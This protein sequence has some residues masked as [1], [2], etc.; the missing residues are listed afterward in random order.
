MKQRD[1]DLTHLKDAFPPMPENCRDALLTAA[2]SV[3]EEQPMKRTSFRA[4]LIVAAILIVTM[5]AAIAATQMGWVDFFGHYDNIRVPKAAQETLNATETSTYTVGPLTF[6]VKQLLADGHIAMSAVQARA[7]DGSEALYSTDEIFDPIGAFGDTALLKHFN[8]TAE[9]PWVDAAK[10]LNIPLY[11]VRA[12]LEINEEYIGGEAMEDPLWNEDGSIVYFN[13]PATNPETVKDSLPATLYLAVR[14][15]D[16]ATGEEV[17]KWTDRKDITIPVNGV[18]ES[19]NYLP[20]DGKTLLGFTVESVTAERTC[21]GAYLTL[22][23]TA[24]EGMNNPDA[25]HAVIDALTLLDG[26]GAPL[27]DGINL[28]IIPNTDAWPNA[29]IEYHC[30]VDALPE[31]IQLKTD[32]AT[33]TLK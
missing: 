29:T 33:L 10:K 9:T 25:V 16:P 27:P 6:T 12:L 30:G 7:T 17:E 23:L 1:I 20:E 15:Y 18:V 26:A 2:R 13:M 24:G 11:G 28:S 5:A 22:Y 31:A 21:A 32:D 3:R 19:K 8:L 4:A 14:R